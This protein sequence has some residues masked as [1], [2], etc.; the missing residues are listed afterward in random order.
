M[1]KNTKLLLTL[2]LVGTTLFSCGSS[3]TPIN[4]AKQ[5]NQQTEVVETFNIVN[6]TSE[7]AYLDG[8]PE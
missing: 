1:K 2:T 6:A 5:E 8:L 4:G 7:Y 3:V